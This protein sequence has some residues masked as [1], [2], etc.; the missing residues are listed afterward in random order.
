[1]TRVLSRK[2]WGLDLHACVVT[3]ARCLG[4]VLSTAGFCKSTRIFIFPSCDWQGRQTALQKAG[5]ET[6]ITATPTDGT[7]R[8]QDIPTGALLHKSDLR[9][10]S[11]TTPVLRFGLHHGM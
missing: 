8:T 10:T 9:N 6:V 4:T 5:E 1:M 3:G 2:N 11:P 7:R